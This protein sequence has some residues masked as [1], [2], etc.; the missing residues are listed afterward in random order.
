MSNFFSSSIG[1]K[2]FMSITGIFLMLFLL[3]HLTV[4]SLLLIGDGETFNRAAHFMA[5]NPATR[6]IE[7]LLA[8]GFVLHIFYAG[9]ITLKNQLARPVKYSKIDRTATTSWASRNMFVLGGL[10]LVFL[11]IH[12]ANFFWKVKF[13]GI[14]EIAYDGEVME[15]LYLEVTNLFENW[16]W[17][18]VIYV[19]GGLLLGF[20]LTHGFWSAFQTIGWDNDKWIKRLKAIGTV[21][22]II[23]AGGFIFIPIYFYITANF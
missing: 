19:L 18:D 9:Y 13:G 11:V 23:I 15:N 16:W 8:L 2:F 5:T 4:N 20:H 14:P 6:I 3:V 10:V 22:A 12:L 7:P 21:Y 1:Q 17:Y